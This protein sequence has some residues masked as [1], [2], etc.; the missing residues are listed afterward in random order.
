MS[1]QV[2]AAKAIE[3]LGRFF[4]GSLGEYTKE[5]PSRNALAVANALIEHLQQAKNNLYCL[6]LWWSVD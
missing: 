4:Q 3:E 5:K 6:E 1:L 2:C